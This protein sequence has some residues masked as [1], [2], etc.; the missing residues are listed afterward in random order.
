MR[1]G[2]SPSSKTFETVSDDYSRQVA[3]SVLRAVDTL[4]TDIDGDT[5]VHASNAIK[6][7]V[8]IGTADGGSKEQKCLA[9]LAACGTPNMLA[10]VRD[11]AH[12]I[13]RS[14]QDA[15]TSETT[16]Q[17]WYDDVFG[18]KHALVP[19]IMNSDAWLEKLL[20]AQRVLLQWQ[21][22]QGGAL[23]IAQHVRRFAKQ[24]FESC[25]SP[26][27]QFCCMYVAI[28][29]VLAFVAS[30]PRSDSSI[31]KRA[32]QRL[33]QMP[34]FMLPQGL[35]ASW[36]A[37]ALEFVRLFD[38]ADHDPAL[39][40]GQWQSFQGRMTKLF[41]DGHIFMG[42]DANPGGMTAPQI[43][44]E[45]A[46]AAR[47]IYYNDSVVHLYSKPSWEVMRAAADSIQQVTKAALERMDVEFGILAQR[48]CSR[49]STLADGRMLRRCFA[50][51]RTPK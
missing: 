14:T 43:I 39:T 21:G 31:R 2:G 25:A 50:K 7:K 28:A 23:S 42:K 35:A 18:A 4:C 9:F 10:A 16:F 20:L 44:W 6:M 36:S 27:R 30:E 29:L 38:V 49:C 11:P 33:R 15:L 26:Q 5:D 3:V 19:D 40:W 45:A 1:R 32:E 41:F 8:R 46:K 37:E 24:R 48:S 51:A 34:S 47:P 13:R 17:A 12:Q 22:S